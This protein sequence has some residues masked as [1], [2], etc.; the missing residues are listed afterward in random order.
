MNDPSLTLLRHDRTFRWYWLGQ[1]ISVAGTE[2]A[3]FALPMV[4]VLALEASVG[5]VS[6]VATA[7]MLPYLLFSLAV[8]HVIEG[9]DQR[10]LM[11][12][13]N[14]VQ[15]AAVAIIPVAWWLDMLSVP[16][17]AVIAF[18]AGTAGLVFGLSAFSYI[19]TMVAAQHL[20]AANRAVQGT[21]TVAQ[22]A[23]PGVAGAV[24]NAVGAPLAMAANAIGYV[25]GA[26]GVW[27]GHVPPRA[28]GAA[29]A[30]RES[31]LTG[32]R[33]LYRN[34]Y[35]RWLTVHAAGYNFAGQIVSINVLIWAVRSQGVDAGVYG[36]ALSAAGVGGLIGTLM[37]LRWEDALGMG[38]AFA[39]SAMVSTAPF[40][41]V[42]LWPFTGWAMAAVIGLVLFVS[43]I[44]LGGSNIFSLTM[45]QIVIPADQRARSAGAY[46]QV[47]YGTIPLGSAVAGM[48]GSAIG[49]RW[50]VLVGAILLTASALPMW[51]T[52]MRGLRFPRNDAA[53]EASAEA[54]GA[55]VAD[56]AS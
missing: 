43:N 29:D 22:V 49:S 24:V 37:A 38:R 36:I 51:T 30:P 23:G 9:K 48:L 46:S 2:I 3:E 20:A 13:A 21:R 41:V 56:I 14:L 26:F 19:P 6:T 17:L 1:S 11:V 40:L 31:M 39:V 34:P 4:S 52:V 45:R 44:G 47:M 55:E 53:A 33:I 35:L 25:A 8:G 54:E 18:V 16:L 50:A 7:A 5:E 12:P 15:A 10:T 32:L 28:E 42:V 27:K